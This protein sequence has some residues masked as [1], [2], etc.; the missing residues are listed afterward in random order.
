MIP[1][2]LLNSS[3]NTAPSLFPNTALADIGISSRSLSGL[4]TQLSGL[5]SSSSLNSEKS[6]NSTITSQAVDDLI[7]GNSSNLIFAAPGED[8]INGGDE[9]NNIYASIGNKI[10]TTGVSDDSIYAGDGNDIINAGDGNNTIFAGEGNNRIITGKDNDFIT[11]GNGNNIIYTGAGDSSIY[12]GNGNN[13]INAGTGNDT[14]T[15]GTGNNQIILEAGEG[16]LTVSGFNVVAD[17]LRLGGSLFDKSVTFVTQMG[18]TIVKAGDDIL[19]TIKNVTAANKS[20]LSGDAPLY[21]YEAIDLGATSPNANNV[22][23]NA[24]NDE[25]QIAGRSE[26]G[27]TVKL[28]TATRVVS[29]GFI[30]ENGVMKPLT[31]TGVK[32]G[33]GPKNGETV[34]QWGGGGFVSAINDLAIVAGTS[35]EILGQATDR[36]LIWQNDGNGYNLNIYDFGGIESYFFDINNQNQIAGRHIY[37]PGSTA[38]ASTRSHPIYRQDGFVNLLPDL[39]G[40]TGTARGINS[41][42]DIVGQLDSDGLNDKTVDN[43][44][45]WQKGEDGKYKFT[46]LGTF[47]SQQAVARDI[48]DSGQIIGWTANGTGATATSSPFLLQD[49]KKIDIGTFGGRLGETAGINQFGQVV[50]YSQNEA[51][52]DRAFVWN[53]GKM[54]DLNN[55]VMTNLTFKGSS[56]T[57]SRANG[58]NNFGDIVAYGSYT[59]KDAA[60]VTQTGTRGYLLKAMVTT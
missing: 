54:S 57:L 34:T 38:T 21:Y 8:I 49:G 30:W 15:I 25:G 13:V 26:S 2:N 32:N 45:I 29:E 47:G 7:T 59:Y 20:L 48:N 1:D 3:L 9:A 10:I 31:S 19:A 39:N 41:K 36:G 18:D 11:A 52:Q 12:A 58:I 51:G 27:A 37:G 16:S 4:D 5:T 42:G 22:R 17:R 56:V 28:G 60:G 33:G 14:V 24:I 55:L 44:V 35:D 43:A 23:A 40:D 46:N 6:A 53:D 50:G